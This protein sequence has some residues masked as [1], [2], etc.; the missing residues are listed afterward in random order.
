MALRAFGQFE[1]AFARDLRVIGRIDTAK[2]RCVCRQGI[3]QATAIDHRPR[4]LGGGLASA[5]PEAITP[6]T[7]LARNVT[8]FQ[9]L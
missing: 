8:F 9:L 6:T 5:N 2:I 4:S 1:N 3:Q 7:A